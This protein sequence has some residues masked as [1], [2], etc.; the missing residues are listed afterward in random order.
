MARAVAPKFLYLLVFHR[1]WKVERAIPLVAGQAG[2]LPRS[3]VAMPTTPPCGASVQQ[4]RSVASG[5]YSR[6]CVAAFQ[7]TPCTTCFNRLLQYARRLT[8]THWLRVHNHPIVCS[9]RCMC[10]AAPVLPKSHLQIAGHSAIET[11]ERIGMENVHPAVH[12]ITSLSLCNKWSGRSRRW[13][14]KPD[15]Y[16]A[17]AWRTN[18][19]RRKVERAIPLVAG[20]AGFLPR[21]CVANQ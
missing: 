21:S 16:H 10:F 19:S 9:R 1:V 4:L 13:R 2:F 20:Q 17:T 8:I 3:C 11:I 14:D 7:K 12:D 15:F 18:A 5:C 6:C